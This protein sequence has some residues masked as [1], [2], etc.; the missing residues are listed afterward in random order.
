MLAE[1]ERDVPRLAGDDPFALEAILRRLRSEG[2]CGGTRMA[3]DGALHDWIGRRLG[4]PTW[5]LLGLDRAGAATSYTIGIDTVDG[6]ADRARRAAHWGALKVKVGGASDLARL[7]AV[8]EA[9]AGP[10]RIDGNEGWDLEIARAIGPE[11]V[12]LGVELVEQPF[13]R[14]DV[15]AY[16]A[17]RELPGRL[18][19]FADESCHDA[20]D[21]PGLVGLVDG[22]NVKLSKTGGIRAAQTAIRVAR[23]HGLSVMIGCMIES[24]LGIAQAAQLGSLA[25]HLDLDGHLLIVDG[26]YRGLDLVAG[27]V[28]PAEAPGLGVEPA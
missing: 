12:R 14:E 8:R 20:G 6:T 1:A 11:L 17:Y 9:F 27:A 2:L 18:P 22:V 16:R 25:D 4:Q 28:L 3:V 26:P 19:V 23:A 10:I 15:D 21:V 7:E 24:E 13:H 5:R